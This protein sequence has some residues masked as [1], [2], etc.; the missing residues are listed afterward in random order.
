MAQVEEFANSIKG[1]LSIDS[2]QGQGTTIEIHC[3]AVKLKHD[4]IIHI[5]DE[6]LLQKS[7]KRYFEQRG[8]KVLSYSSPS[9]YIKEKPIRFKDMPIFIDS[10][11]GDE[12]RGEEFAKEL[13]S[14]GFKEIYLSSA[15]SSHISLARYPWI[16]SSM[17][18]SAKDALN[19]LLMTI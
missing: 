19:A 5:D 8:I 3:L 18:K 13:Y 10:Y 6:V 12:I 4:T 7:W 17:G 15:D 11:M 16:L 2:T 14:D 9:D 1:T